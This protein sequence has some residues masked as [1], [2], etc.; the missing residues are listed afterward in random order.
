MSKLAIAIAVFAAY[1]VQT[2]FLPVIRI[3]GAVPDLLLIVLVHVALL[4]W[5]AAGAILGF[6]TGLLLD[7]SAPHTL[8]AAALSRSVVGFAIGHTWDSVERGSAI[9][10]TAAVFAAV[11]LNDLLYLAAVAMSA[12]GSFPS[13]L[14]SVALPAALYTT[15]AAP[16][17][18]LLLAR[19]V[20]VRRSARRAY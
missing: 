12:R 17:V 4:R 5:P 3:W 20:R 19:F 16:P 11:I 1:L 2:S 18:L 9:T 13:T 8:G 10:V 15:L 14:L 6:L 7:L